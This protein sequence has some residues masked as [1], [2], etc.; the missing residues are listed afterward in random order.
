MPWKL[1]LFLILMVF[2]VV[3]AGFNLENKTSI[4]FGFTVINDVPIFISLF[5]AFVLGVI[6]SV[7]VFLVQNKKRRKKYEKQETVIM[8]NEDNTVE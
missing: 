4:S 3:F 5:F 8:D 2:F 6:V 1:V 7:P